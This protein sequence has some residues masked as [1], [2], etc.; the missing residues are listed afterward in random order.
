MAGSLVSFRHESCNFM[1]AE[2]PASTLGLGGNRHYYVE[3]I[4]K[5]KRDPNLVGP[6]PF[7]PD[8]L[9]ACAYLSSPLSWK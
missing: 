4:P 5:T 1:L 2:C 3:A 8:T 6:A 9:Y 7:S